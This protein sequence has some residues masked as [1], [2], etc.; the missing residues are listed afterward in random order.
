MYVNRIGNYQLLG[1][2]V[3]D[4]A[5]EAFDKT[6][7]LLGLDYPGGAA[8]SKLAETGKNAGFDLPRPM[9]HSKD[10]DF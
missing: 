6:A 5:G 8:L 3:D 10:L 1:E 2:T 4:A 7:K 9:L